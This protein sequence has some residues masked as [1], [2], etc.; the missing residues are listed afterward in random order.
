MLSICPRRAPQPAGSI[1]SAGIL[2][3]HGTGR[4]RRYIAGAPH[5]TIQDRRRATR[6]PFR[7]P[8]PWMRAELAERITRNVLRRF[9][10]SGDQGEQ[11]AR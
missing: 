11:E 7:A 6:K 5:R 3:S 10:S 9:S 1:A 4:S 2:S 8:Y